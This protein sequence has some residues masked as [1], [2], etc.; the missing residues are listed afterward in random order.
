MKYFYSQDSLQSYLDNINSSLPF[1]ARF[2]TEKA[3]KVSWMNS[4]KSASFIVESI[5]T[6][7]FDN[8]KEVDE[9][10]HTAGDP[11]TVSISNRNETI[12]I[13]TS[14]ETLS[15]DR[16]LV[17]RV[18]GQL[19]DCLR[20]TGKQ[21]KS[22]S[23]TEAFDSLPQATSSSFPDFRRPKSVVKAKTLK[24]VHSIVRS[25]DFIFKDFPIS[26]NWRTQ[27]SSSGKLKYRQ[28]YPFPLAVAIIEKML[29]MGLFKHFETCKS[30][31]YCFANTFPD[32]K[33]RYGMWQ[34]K[35]FIVSLDFGSFDQ[36]MVN[37]IILLVMKFLCSKCNFTGLEVKLS[38]HI[39]DYHCQCSIISSKNGITCLFTKERGLMSG[40]SLTNLIGSVANLFMLLYVNNKYRLN[41]DVKSISILGDDII[42]ATDKYIDIPEISKIYESEFQAEVNLEKSKIFHPGEKVF[43]LGHEFD[44][45]GRYLDKERVKLQLSISENYIPEEVLSTGDRIFGKFCSILFKCSDG[46][47]YY[48]HH[49]P[50]LLSIARVEEKD[51]FYGIFNDSG[52]PML[53]YKFEEYKTKG[54]VLQ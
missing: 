27:I 29:F 13:L 4:K 20:L 15:L 9:L 36:R 5:F 17:I 53:R 22:V 34:K 23:P 8:R 42:F 41:I 33:W 2:D 49:A 46:S 24:I 45:K 6:E 48:D 10:I 3:A 11:K 14:S 19:S 44:D 12:K 37:C 35:K 25:G 7:L 28:F 47:D 26:I 18:I 31:P 50:R 52:N 54:W 43:F 16:T 39:M 40:S 30:T 51:Y 21:Y 38:K 1:Y 32:L